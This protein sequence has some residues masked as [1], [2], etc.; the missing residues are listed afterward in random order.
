MNALEMPNRF[1]SLFRPCRRVIP[2]NK[3]IFKIKYKIFW[4]W[5]LHH[6]KRFKKRLNISKRLYKCL[7]KMNEKL[8]HLK[9]TSV[10][11]DCQCKGVSSWMSAGQSVPDAKQDARE[12]T[13]SEYCLNS[14]VKIKSP[15][16]ATA[17]GQHERSQHRDTRTC[18]LV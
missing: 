12:P 3:M 9:R 8:K 2:M 13:K 14:V 5:Y 1:Q 6:F 4:P 16:K 11:N 17:K 18:W 10:V 15:S 7:E